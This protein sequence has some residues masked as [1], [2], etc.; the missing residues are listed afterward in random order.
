MLTFTAINLWSVEASGPSI[1][2]RVSSVLA[3]IEY[4]RC[5]LLQSMILA[6]FSLF[7]SLS[8]GSAVQKRLNGR[9]DV[10]FVVETLWTQGT[11]Y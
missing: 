5:R 8:R 6:S 11:L 7:V 2:K 10:L 1:D 4:I 3:H 9:I